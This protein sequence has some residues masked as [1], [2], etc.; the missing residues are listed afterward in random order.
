MQT[1][2][3]TILFSDHTTKVHLGVVKNVYIF[4][5]PY[6]L[7]VDFVAIVMPHDLFCPIIFVNME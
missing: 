6:M 4:V 2:Q 7:P 1:T 5:G 3:T